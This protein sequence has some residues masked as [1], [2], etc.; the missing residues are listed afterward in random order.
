MESNKTIIYV[1]SNRE[2]ENFEK[3]IRANILGNCGGLPIISVSQKPIN[4]GKNICVGDVGHSYLNEF[5]QILIGAKEAK[6]EYL[7]FCEADFLYPPEYFQFD[8]PGGDLYRYNNVWLMY[9]HRGAIY[10]QKRFSN[11]AQIAKREFII[12]ELEQYLDGFPQWANGRF[13]INKED[14]NGAIFQ[15][16]GG[17]LACV[18][19][20]TGNGMTQSATSRYRK[21][22]YLPYWGNAQDLFDK[23]LK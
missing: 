7:V 1:T 15:L 17:E 21:R 10:Y 20:K 19:F 13:K 22:T 18:S 14:Y 2:N 4:F 8:P 3:E 12:N 16:F 6:T 11:G 23:Y 9:R 5:R